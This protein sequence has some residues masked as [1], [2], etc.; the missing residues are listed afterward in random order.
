MKLTK[1]QTKI[2]ECIECGAAFRNHEVPERKSS[3]LIETSK[4]PSFTRYESSRG[5][6]YFFVTDKTF[7]KIFES[8]GLVSHISYGDYEISMK[9]KAY[10][11]ELQK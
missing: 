2:L 9:G 5:N 1:R 10:L 4:A 7:Y 11:K 8:N 3:V 6:F